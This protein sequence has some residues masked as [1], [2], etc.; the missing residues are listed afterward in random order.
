M[1]VIPNDLHFS[2]FQGANGFA[3]RDI[4]TA[5]LLSAK[6]HTKFEKIIVHYDADGEGPWWQLAR[7]I[8]GITWRRV[9]PLKM[10]VNGYPV[11]DTRLPCDLYRLRTLFNEG[12]VYADLDFIFLGDFSHLL[13]TTAFIGTQC[14]AKK[15]LACGLM[16]STIASDFIRQYRAAYKKW[17]PRHEKT[18]WDY[19]NTV[20][21]EISRA[22]PCH[23]LSMDTFYPWRWSNK[24]FLQ[25]ETPR[26]LKSAIACHL[27]ES[28]Q[29]DL[30]VAD[31][32]K[33]AL[34][35]WIKPFW[36]GHLEPAA[37]ACSSE[38]T[39]AES[40]AESLHPH[41]PGETACN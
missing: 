14:L 21:W 34:E 31:L 41:P 40:S 13:T 15:K 7:T 5:C 35:P 17:E 20:P 25:G 2:Y 4:H 23:V 39:S 22:T 36:G 30:T 10:Q 18:F 12:G 33:T 27:W 16:G 38:S 37:E 19:A 29:P 32:L 3:W 26:G 9:A 24:T 1:S 28:I 8:P 11:S 6:A